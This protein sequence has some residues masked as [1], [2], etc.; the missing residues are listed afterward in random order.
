MAKEMEVEYDARTKKIFCFDDGTLLFNITTA[1]AKTLYSK[2]G[3]ALRY[4]IP[5]LKTKVMI[6]KEHPHVM[7]GKLTRY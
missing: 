3:A 4:K 6:P 5:K 7:T 2:L 1:K